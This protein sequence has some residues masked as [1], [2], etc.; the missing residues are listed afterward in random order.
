MN[1]HDSGNVFHLSVIGKRLG[2]IE[3]DTFCSVRDIS[4]TLV[5]YFAAKGEVVEENELILPGAAML[6]APN[7]QKPEKDAEIGQAVDL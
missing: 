3:C 6:L 7:L 1:S 2:A 5:H 4:G